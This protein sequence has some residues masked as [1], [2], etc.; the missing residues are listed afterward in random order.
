MDDVLDEADEIYQMVHEG[1]I[2]QD[3]EFLMDLFSKDDRDSNHFKW[4]NAIE[5]EVKNSHRK[6]ANHL[7]STL[8][9][10][11]DKIGMQFLDL[12]KGFLSFL[13]YKV[14]SDTS[15]VN[16]DLLTNKESLD[17]PFPENL[18]VDEYVRIGPENGMETDLRPKKKQRTT[19]EDISILMSAGDKKESKLAIING[20]DRPMI[21]SKKSSDQILFYKKRR[22]ILDHFSKQ[23]KQ[24]QALNNKIRWRTLTPADFINWPQNLPVKHPNSYKKSEFITRLE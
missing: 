21:S 7:S 13:D 18:F 17:L 12:F 8:D 6:N 3:Q 5:P 24:N 16:L 9:A 20:S 22:L 23:L 14:P 2:L 15:D 1:F 19:G 11:I 10:E 4:N